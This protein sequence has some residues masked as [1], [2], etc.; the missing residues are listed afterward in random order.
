MSSQDL[1]RFLLL[2]GSQTGQAQ[3]IA[4]EIY[5]QAIEKGYKPDIHCLSMSEKKVRYDKM[6]LSS[7]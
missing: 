7:V 1:K 3:S 4:E 2:Y 5:R 6:S